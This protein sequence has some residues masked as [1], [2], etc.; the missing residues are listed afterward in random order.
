MKHKIRKFQI[1]TLC[2]LFLSFLFMTSVYSAAPQR[3]GMVNGDAVK[4]EREKEQEEKGEISL[5]KG[6][7][8]ETQK[9]SEEKGEEEEKVSSKET[10]EEPKGERWY[11]KYWWIWI[12]PGFLILLGLGVA[13]YYFVGWIKSKKR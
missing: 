10:L 11:K 3:S 1:L 12:C 7:T 9:V 13:I 5:Q 4:V 2:P 6:T 8:E